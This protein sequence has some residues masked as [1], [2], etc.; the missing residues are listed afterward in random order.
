MPSVTLSTGTLV[1][2]LPGHSTGTTPNPRCHNL[3]A[4]GQPV[5]RCVRRSCTRCERPFSRDTRHTSTQQQQQQQQPQAT[6]HCSNA[7]HTVWRGN[8]LI[9]CHQM[10]VLQGICYGSLTPATQQLAAIILRK[11]KLQYFDLSW[12]CWATCCT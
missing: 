4:T 10:H 5:M 12:P 3:S 9:S 8:L 11:H 6:M 1:S 2:D 7:I